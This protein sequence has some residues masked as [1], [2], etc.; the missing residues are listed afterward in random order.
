MGFSPVFV[1]EAEVDAFVSAFWRVVF[2]LP[3]LFIWARYEKPAS[4]HAVTLTAPAVIA[5]LLFAG[6]LVFWHLAIHYTTLAN[7][8][9]MVCLAPVWVAALSP[10]V[11]NEK[12]AI[13]C[14]KIL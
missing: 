6:D 7:A 10:F 2:A 12:Q 4:F 5:G 9:F 11:L 1:R 14:F 3:V 8:T 13:T